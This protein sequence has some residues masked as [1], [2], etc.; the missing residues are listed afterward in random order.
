[1]QAPLPTGPGRRPDPNSR[2]CSSQASRFSATI[3]L[4]KTPKNEYHA[5]SDG[6]EIENP[7]HQRIGVQNIVNLDFCDLMCKYAKNPD[8][9]AIDGSG[10]CMTFAALYCVLKKSLVHKNLPCKRKVFKKELPI[11]GK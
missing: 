11:N 5:A 2:P 4:P 1:M 8:K 10:S 6:F 9:E 7:S 3:F